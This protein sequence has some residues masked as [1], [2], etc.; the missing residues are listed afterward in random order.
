MYHFVM[1]RIRWASLAPRPDGCHVARSHYTPGRNLGSHAHD[2]AEICWVEAGEL[3]HDSPQRRDR[4][5]P[6]AAVLIRPEHSHGLR[7][8]PRGTRLV[9]IAIDAGMLARLEERYADAAWPWHAAADGGPRVATLSPADLAAVGRRFEDFA[10][11]DDDPLGRDAFLCDLL[12][13]LRPERQVVRW[14][15]APP[16][17]ADALAACAEP[18]HLAEGL[19]A[20][21]RFAGRSREHCARVMRRDCGISPSAAI[22]DLRLRH[23]E[24]ELSLGEATVSTIAAQCGY[25]NRT[26]FTHLFEQRYG[27]TPGVYRRRAR[28]ASG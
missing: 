13:R 3:V 15:G 27:C 1:R 12:Q 9:N 19:P 2:F 10:R 22:R 25:A 28:L 6:G 5:G 4:M 26:R 11:I 21:A 8:G 24:R 20:L 7:G 18:P 23:A 14:P 16:W 17:L